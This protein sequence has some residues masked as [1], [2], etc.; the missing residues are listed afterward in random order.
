MDMKMATGYYLNVYEESLCGSTSKDI[1]IV[2]NEAN[3]KPTIEELEEIKAVVESELKNDPEGTNLR[4]VIEDINFP[5]VNFGVQV[6]SSMNNSLSISQKASDI[7]E[8]DPMLAREIYEQKKME[9]AIEDITARME[10]NLKEMNVNDLSRDEIKKIAESFHDTVDANGTFW[11][12]YWEAADYAID[13]HLKEREGNILL[14][15][16]VNK[17]GKYAIVGYDKDNDL[18][19]ILETSDDLEGLKVRGETLFNYQLNSDALRSK[20]TNEPFDWFEICNTEEADYP[21]HYYW[22]SYDTSSKLTSLGNDLD[23]K[24]A[25]A[26]YIRKEEKQM[27][28]KDV[29]RATQDRPIRERGE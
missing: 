23:E 8:K 7:I 29:S 14:E 4:Q 15:G 13:E 22:A 9:Y 11:D 28:D 26:D 2:F 5:C 19:E 20:K 10:D 27:P 25:A 1:F 6:I 24:I 17:S 12:V 16:Q 18:Y 21:N 3:S